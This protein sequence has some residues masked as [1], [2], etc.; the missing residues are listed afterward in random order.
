MK[1]SRKIL[2]IILTICM[3]MHILPVFATESDKDVASGG[4]SEITYFI[5]D[6]F[7]TQ[8]NTDSWEHGAVFEG[9]KG[10]VEQATED[11]KGVLKVSNEGIEG[12]DATST[13]NGKQTVAI[14]TDFNV[15]LTGEIE[16]N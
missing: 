4:A 6:H 5:N 2:S 7:E 8:G 14:K 10:I 15:P 12:C 13:A 11:G 16:D 1:N 3:V 9:F